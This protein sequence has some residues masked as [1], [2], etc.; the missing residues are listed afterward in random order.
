[1][2]T[3]REM[4]AADLPKVAELS[5]Q[6]GYPV[7]LGELE[8]RFEIL[9][10]SKTNVL[11]VAGEPVGGWIQ[12]EQRQSL[13]SGENAEIVG[14]VVDSGR[15][16]EGLGRALVASAEQWAKDRSLP[17]LRVRSNVT[18]EESHR[19][20]PAIGFQKSKTQHVY[21]KPCSEKR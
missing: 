13:E 15:R 21:E 8:K 4:S 14:L 5:G 19:F 12:V 1:M 18:R 6:L 17:K 9:R 11:F 20:Y 7:S 3:V 10:A 2:T 16:R